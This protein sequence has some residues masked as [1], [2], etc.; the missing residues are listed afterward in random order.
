MKYLHF[1]C[2]K[3]IINNIF[4]QTCSDRCEEFKD[5]VQCQMYGTG[6]Y[7]ESY[8]IETCTKFTPISV[9]QVEGVYYLH[10]QLRKNFYPPYLFL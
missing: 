7:N 4:V 6:R 3:I 2:I 5:C 8:C 10:L 9:K 1:F